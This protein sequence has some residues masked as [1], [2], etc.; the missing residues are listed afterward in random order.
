MQ[1]PRGATGPE[2]PIGPEGQRGIQGSIGP[3]GVP[4]PIGD[5]GFTGPPGESLVV[6]GS[7]AEYMIMTT[8][9]RQPSDAGKAYYAEDTGMLYIYRSSSP[10]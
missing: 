6:A 10:Y 2:G 4:G 9:P 8:T 5:T 1:G 3:T 7:F